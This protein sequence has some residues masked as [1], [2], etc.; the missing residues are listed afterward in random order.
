[1]RKIKYIVYGLCSLCWLGASCTRDLGNYTYHEIDKLEISGID[2]KNW[3]QKISHVDTLKIYPQVKNVQTG[4]A[5]G[6]YAY[7]W[8]IIPQGADY[9]HGAN[10]KDYVVARTPELEYPITEAAGRYMCYF[11]VEDTSTGVVW[12]QKFYLQVSSLTSEGWM[13]LCEQD[14]KSRMDMIVNVKEDEDVISRDIWSSG[15]FDPGKPL[16]LF[17][18]YAESFYGGP[19]AIFVSDKGSFLLDKA[20]MH[21]GEDNSIRWSFGSQPEKTFVTG[22]GISANSWVHTGPDIYDGEYYDLHWVVVDELGDVY[23]NTIT[24]YG[25]VFDLPVN[26]INGKEFKAAPFVANSY[27]YQGNGDVAAA[28]TM[29][30]DLEGRFLEIKAEAG[31]PTVMK[32]TGP[33]LFSAEQPGKEMVHLQSTVGD[34]L[35]FA[36][37]KD[38]AG[39]YFYYGI[40]LGTLG[41][42]TQKYYGQITGPGLDKVSHFAFHPILGYLFYAVQDKVYTIDLKNPAPA[43]EVLSF[44][45]ETIKVLKFNPLVAGIQ[46]AA[47][48]QMRSEHLLVGTTVNALVSAKEI[49][50]GRVRTYEISPLADQAPRLKKEHNRLGNI[51][52]VVYKETRR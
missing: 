1:M 21:V 26:K 52:D 24:D 15:D 38:A 17:F 2:D 48:E 5:A 35:T 46:Y 34:G 22:S 10:D 8:K 49:D 13:V 23:V 30:Y 6:N 36:V 7:E 27:N 41:V 37:L 28:S 50:C 29:L 31:R 33:T 11:N 19:R 12:S 47:W 14:G 18:N 25:G 16:R 43:K 32:F 20:D 44:P 3:Y 39:N 40:V 45:G 51:V 9:D 42:N 4:T